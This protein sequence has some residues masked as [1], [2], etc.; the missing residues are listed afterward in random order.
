MNEYNQERF[1]KEAETED[2]FY[3]I[4]SY[5]H[6]TGNK[7]QLF[8]ASERP[9]FICEYSDG[10]KIGME[11]TMITRSP[12]IRQWDRIVEKKQFMDSVEVIEL[13]QLQTVEKDEKR[14]EED[15]TFS[16]NA[17]LVI[18]LKDISLSEFKPFLQIENFPDLYSTGFKE[19]WL[20]D[21][22][23]VE[24]YDSINTFCLKP[25]DS[26]GFYQRLNP[27]QKPFG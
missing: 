11:L 2:L 1:K 26:F 12:K 27:Y 6:A 23:E 22:S 10:S 8:E 5:Q 25:K 19:I 21:Y 4:E 17:I 15:W 24:A 14:A 18:Q 13:I 3:F 7:L 9:D 16:N 20:G